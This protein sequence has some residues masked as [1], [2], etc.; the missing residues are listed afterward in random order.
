MDIN[1]INDVHNALKEYH[2]LKGIM[3]EY[4]T[5]LD[6][7][8]KN[9][10]SY[11]KD[12]NIY[13]DDTEYASVTYVS[14]SSTTKYEIRMTKLTSEEKLSLEEKGAIVKKTSSKDP[15]YRIE[16]NNV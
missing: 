15:Y 16:L 2:D 13:S 4:S 8:R 14:G 1:S 10:I 3:N 5:K 12:N 6:N 11:Y 7:L 9:I